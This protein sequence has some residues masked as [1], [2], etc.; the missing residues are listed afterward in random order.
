MKPPDPTVAALSEELPDGA[1]GSA[2]RVL[3][4]GTILDEFEVEEII[5]EG[6]ATIIYA[7]TERSRAVPVAIAEY[8]PALIAQRD[9][10]AQVTPR[11]S[12][13]ADVFARGLKAFISETR[14]LAECDHSS[15]VRIVG[16]FEVNATAYR[17][18]PR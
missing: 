6:D 5:D 10:A 14:T 2:A 12:A 9:D 11:T 4:A 18:M 1:V 15:L 7:A 8:M 16:R 13:R 3:P 17:V